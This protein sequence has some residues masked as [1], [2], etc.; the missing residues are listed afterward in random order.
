MGPGSTTDDLRRYLTALMIE[1][2]SHFVIGYEATAP[3]KETAARKL[4]AT[5]ADGLNG[6]KRKAIVKQTIVIPVD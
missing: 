3:T 2:R 6:E 5:V 4:T 1:L